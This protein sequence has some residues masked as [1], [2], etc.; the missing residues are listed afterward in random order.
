MTFAKPNT[1]NYR[2]GKINDDNDP[3]PPP[4]PCTVCKEITAHEDLMTYGARCWKCYDIY[5]RTAPPFIA[6]PNKYHENDKK[7]WA[8]RIMDKHNEG[9]PVSK[10]ALEFAKEALKI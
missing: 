8:K 10:I 5:C 4:K 6:E 7:A 3:P 2:G 1:E 9:R